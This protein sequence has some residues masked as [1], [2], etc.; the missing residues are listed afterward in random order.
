MARKDFESAAYEEKLQLTVVSLTIG[1]K[2]FDEWIWLD[3][4]SKANSQT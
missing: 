1:Y 2:G 3:S 4:N